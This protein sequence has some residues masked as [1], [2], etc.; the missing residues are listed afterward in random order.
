MRLS[1][2]Q[3]TSAAFVIPGAALCERHNHGAQHYWEC[4]S[5]LSPEL[6]IMFSSFF[7]L[8]D[9]SFIS[10]VDYIICY[11]LIP[12]VLPN[13]WVRDYFWQCMNQ[14]H[15]TRLS[16]SQCWR[17]VEWQRPYRI[18]CVCMCVV[19][20]VLVSTG[21]CSFRSDTCSAPLEW[22]VVKSLQGTCG[23][24]GQLTLTFSQRL[25][26]HRMHWS[27][28]EKWRKCLDGQDAL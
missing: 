5:K 18:E 2:S 7:Q 4:K 3:M 13:K 17:T 12:Q 22:Q 14:I 6:V 11:Q 9:W 21:G 8:C 15:W 25:M 16:F 28:K 1:S 19:T 10:A 27:D 26:Y 20:A 24:W 23:E